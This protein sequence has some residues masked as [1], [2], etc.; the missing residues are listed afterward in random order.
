MTYEE[1]YQREL[2]KL[3]LEWNTTDA[4]EIDEIAGMQHDSP[5]FGTEKHRWISTVLR[6]LKNHLAMIAPPPK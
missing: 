6:L 5:P 3:Q 2:A 4:F 1:N